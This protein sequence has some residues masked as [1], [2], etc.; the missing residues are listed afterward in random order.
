MKAAVRF[1]NQAQFHP[2]KFLLP[3][4][5][6]ITKNGVQIYEKTRIVSI[7]ENENGSYCLITNQG[8]K[9]TAEKIIIASHYPFYN[10]PAFYFTRIYPER[11]YVVAIK[12]KENYPG[13]MYIT[14][15]EP[16]R[17][18][19]SQMT[20]QG[21]LI[22]IGGEHHKT[23]QGED[24]TTHY[25]KLIDFANQTF[26]VEQIP[27]RWSTQDC[28]TLD[29]LP[30]VGQF[31]SKKPNIYIATGFGKWGM[32]NSIASAMIIRDLILEGKSPWQDVYNPS[33][34]TIAASTKTFVVENLNVAGKI[35]QGKLSLI[36]DDVDVKPEEGKII[37][38]DGQRT[39]VYK[40]IN[41]NLHIVDTTCQ[42]M[43]CE[44]YWNAAE[45][46][47]DC[48]CHGSRFSIDGDIVEGPTVQ[49]L[50]TEKKINPI[51][52][53]LKEDF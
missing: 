37:E 50:N 31:T 22:F 23:G 20:D 49:P 47:W 46:T 43:G 30:Y 11:S 39:G 32:T 41:G 25:E 1:D 21:Q 24:T 34:H 36:P 12:A 5:D 15:E 4:A 19:R 38:L 27:Y 45:K 48:P 16:G 26:T 33:R 35:V 3:I 8:N 42:H 2:R 13:G 44:L 53:L 18:L 29:D 6:K 9:V 28:M 17:S 14:A 10:K 51:G 7:E 40:D 52:K